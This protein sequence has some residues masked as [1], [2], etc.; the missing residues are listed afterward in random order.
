MANH[1]VRILYF[2]DCCVLVEE[3]V[4]SS[5][6]IEIKYKNILDPI[7]MLIK[8][9]V[10]KQKVMAFEIGGDGIFKYL[11]RLCVPDIDGLRRRIFNEAHEFHYTVHPGSTKT[12][13]ILRRSICGMT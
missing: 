12:N 6:G 13:I 9:D 3:V 1:G 10:G 7:L 11:G 2:E 8:E 5:L 4:K